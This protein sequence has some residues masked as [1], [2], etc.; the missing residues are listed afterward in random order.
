[1]K[2]WIQP[3]CRYLSGTTSSK[4][5]VDIESVHTGGY[6]IFISFNRYYFK[7]V[8]LILNW[9]YT[10]D[11]D[12]I[13]IGF[14]WILLQITELFDIE[15]VWYWWIWFDFWLRSFHW[16]LIGTTSSKFAWYWIDFILVKFWKLGIS[17]T[18]ANLR[19][20]ALLI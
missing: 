6:F 1:M 16:Y 20:I 15:L 8:C 3:H 13:F 4:V 10:G 18:I 19:R 2:L 14:E 9:F 5:L 11:F 7:Q 12:F 17:Y